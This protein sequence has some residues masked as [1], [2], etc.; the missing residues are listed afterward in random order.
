MREDLRNLIAS[1]L[2]LRPSNA[3]AYLRAYLHVLT[4]LPAINRAHK[5]LALRRPAMTDITT[6][7]FSLPAPLE[8]NGLPLLTKQVVQD[9]YLPLFLLKRTRPMP[10][11]SN[12]SRRANLLLVSNDIVD[13]KMAGPGMRYVEMARALSD[14]LEVTLAVPNETALE[15]P[16]IR[17][18]T[19][20]EAQPE[21]LEIL[22]Q[23]H[24]QTL[25]SGYMVYKFP[26][27]KNTRTRLI[28]DWY[29]P[30]YLENYYYYLDRPMEEQ[31]EH[32]STAIGMLNDLA[33]IGDFFICGN[34]RQRDLWIGILSANKRINP[35]TLKDDETLRKLIDVVGVGIPDRPLN[36]KPILRGVHP[37]FNDKS[38]IVLWGGGIWNWLD[39]LTLAKAW[40]KVAQARPDARLV[41]LG[42]RHPN[43]NVPRHEIVDRLIQAAEDMGEK[44]RTIFFIEW[45]TIQDREALLLE[46][47]I[48]ITLHPI[49]AETRY[50]IRTR[51]L[52]YFWARLPVCITEGDVTSEWVR[53]FQVGSTVPPGD[54]NA[55][56]KTLL[57]MLSEDRRTYDKGFD[58]L[59]RQMSWSKAVE[60][61]RQYALD[62][63]NAPDRDEFRRTMHMDPTIPE[64]MITGT[65]RRAA[66]LWATQGTR[67]ML[68]QTVHHIKF[69]LGKV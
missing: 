50:S 26:F 55:L 18:V 5:T 21:S 54:A 43:P 66:Y 57:S 47:D 60:P 69:L 31:I 28:V 64:E 45:L 37:A 59:H 61:L 36:P 27:L 35:L 42:T 51:V 8:R 39:P 38:Q 12:K 56:A 30:F 4:D 65:V 58:A 7:D 44:D 25:I 10:E 33:R 32:N 23:N 29:D 2:R 20:Q 13:T 63:S 41:F 49:H 6:L 53:S 15:I 11:F 67:A 3:L 52:D 1:I 17:L 40:E 34:E 62:G 48:G 14:S 19:Y 68:S 9:V 24:E 22:V 16:G 46:A